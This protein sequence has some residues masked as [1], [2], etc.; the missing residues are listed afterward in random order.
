[1]WVDLLEKAQTSCLPYFDGGIFTAKGNTGKLLGH[2]QPEIPIGALRVVPHWGA[3]LM[4]NGII[5]GVNS[6]FERVDPSKIDRIARV[7]EKM[8][9]Y[10]NE[11]IWFDGI[12]PKT[13][14]RVVG[15]LGKV[16]LRWTD[17]PDI[18][19]CQRT[20][21]ED[22]PPDVFHNRNSPPFYQM[23]GIGNHLDRLD[24]SE[25]TAML[26]RAATIRQA[27]SLQAM[28]KGMENNLRTDIH[29]D[30]VVMA[31]LQDELK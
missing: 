16:A 20:E 8:E 22:Q 30:A 24:R 11:L 18:Q 6:A 17:T 27:N 21:L 10:E 7:S 28:L 2:L 4:M 31:R 5:G 25:D 12:N 29:N 14:K 1:M 15:P 13:D 3:M 9:T 19:F 26:E 23:I